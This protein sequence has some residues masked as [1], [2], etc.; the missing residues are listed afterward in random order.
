M[1][2]RSRLSLEIDAEGL[3]ALTA[4]GSRIVLAKPTGKGSPNLAWLTFEPRALRTV[5][6]EDL[7]GVFASRAGVRVGATIDVATCVFPAAERQVYTFDGARFAEARPENRVPPG[8]YDVWNAGP[9]A[10]T[11]G[12]MQSASID[13]ATLSTP[14]NAIVLPADFTADFT[15]DERVYVWAQPGVKTGAI[16]DTV[17]ANAALAVFDL[18]NRIRAY[19]YD[20]E[21]SA[22]TPAVV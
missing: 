7:Y 13:D 21:A 2:Q 12:L 8:H 18:R 11:F 17:P 4:A 19:R 1:G 22:F 9:S 5:V 15:P 14:L 10:S 16:I 6:W 20:V 3:A